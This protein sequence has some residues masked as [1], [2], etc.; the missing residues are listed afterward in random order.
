MHS[1]SDQ[2]FTALIVAMNGLLQL[3]DS[4]ITKGRHAGPEIPAKDRLTLAHALAV[5]SSDDHS[6]LG[7]SLCLARLAVGDTVSEIRANFVRQGVAALR[8]L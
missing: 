2:Y 5:G 8:D 7:F 3:L 4:E 1:V 6:S